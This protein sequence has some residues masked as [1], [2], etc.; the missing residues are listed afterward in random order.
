[1][2][3]FHLKLFGQSPMT[4]ACIF[5]ALFA[6]ITNRVFSQTVTTTTTTEFSSKGRCPK[7]AQHN[8]TDCDSVRDECTTSDDCNVVRICC[9]NG[10]QHVCSQPAYTACEHQRLSSEKRSRALALASDDNSTVRIPSCRSNGHFEPV[11]CDRDTGQCWCVD[12]AGFELSGTRVHSNGS[13]NCTAP[14]PCAGHL[15]RMLCPYEFELDDEGCPLCQCRDPCAGVRCPGDTQCQLEEVHCDQEPCPPVPTCKQ[16]RSLDDICPFGKALAVSERNKF[17]LCGLDQGKPQCPSFFDCIVQP[18]MEYG[19]CCPAADKLVKPGT[20]PNLTRSYNDC[21]KKCQHDMECEG[22][23]KCCLS[24]HCG[25]TCAPMAENTVCLQ[26]RILSE[27]LSVREKSGQGYIPQ[28]TEKGLFES[29]QCSRNGL[30]CWCVDVNGFKTPRSMGPAKTVECKS[31][32]EDTAVADPRSC[33]NI[34]C[35]RSCPYGFKV[36]A[37]GC[38]T[39]NCADLCESIRCPTG[40]ECVVIEN[41]FCTE[42]PCESYPACKPSPILYSK[43]GAC[44]LADLVKCTNVTCVN[45]HDCEGSQKCCSTPKCGTTCL[46]NPRPLQRLPTMC[47]YLRDFGTNAIDRVRARSLALPDLVCQP[48]G[49]YDSVQCYGGHC[50]CVNEFGTE[51]LGSRVDD[52]LKD[53]L[54][55]NATMRSKGCDG[56]LCRLGCDYGFEYGDDGCP[57]CSCRNPCGSITCPEGHQCQVVEVDCFGGF[58][59]AVPQCISAEHVPATC[60]VGQALRDPM[61]NVTR[62]CGPSSLCPSSYFCHMQEGSDSSEGLCCKKPVKPGQCPYLF[63]PK[64]GHCANASQCESDHQCQGT[65]KCCSDGCKSACLEPEMKTAC[66]HNAAAAH[67]MTQQQSVLLGDI[68]SPNCE[69]ADGSFSP[70]QCHSLGHICWCVDDAGREI[71]S[72]RT[73][74]GQQPNCTALAKP[75]SAIAL[76]NLTCSHGY[77]LNDKGCG[78]CACRDPCEDILCSRKNEECRMVKV[79]CITEPCPPIAMC[80]PRIDSPCPHGEPLPETRCSSLPGGPSCPS[81]HVCLYSPLESFLPSCCPKSRDVCFEDPKYNECPASN[82]TSWSFN[83][84]KNGC[85]SAPSG[86]CPSTTNGFSNRFDCEA[87]CPN[88]SECER[89][90]EKALHITKKT[91]GFGFIPKCKKDGNWEAMQCLPE[92]GLCWCVSTSGDYIR[93]SAVRGIPRCASSRMGRK[94]DFDE[95]KEE[96]VAVTKFFSQDSGLV[97]PAGESVHLCNASLCEG[98]VCLNQP[99]AVCRVDPCGGCQYRFFTDDHQVDCNEGLTA[100]QLDVQKIL[101]SDPWPPQAM[102]F[103]GVLLGPEI[104]LIGDMMMEALDNSAGDSLP[105]AVARR[106]ADDGFLLPLGVKMDKRT[107]LE[108][109]VVKQSLGDN[110]TEPSLTAL[111]MVVMPPRCTVTGEYASVQRQGELSWCVDQRGQ[112]IHSTLTRGFVRCSLNGVILE[113]QARG[114]V[115]TDSA[116]AHR[117]C[118]NECLNAE[119]PSRPDAICLADPCDNCRVTFVDRSSEKVQCEEKCR[120]P[121]AVGMCRAAFPRWHFSETSGECESFIFGGCLGND[122]N[123]ETE[124]ECKD[125]C[126]KPVDLCDLPKRIGMCRASMK[127]FWY[128][129]QTHQCERFIFG[130]CDGNSNNFETKEQC[131]STCPDVVLCP[132]L[133][134]VHSMQPCK[135]SALCANQTCP[136]D[137]DAV[138]S[139]DPC[140][141]SIYFI[142]FDGEKVE[143]CQ[144]TTS[145]NILRNEFYD[146]T[147]IP[148]DVNLTT[149]ASHSTSMQAN[150]ATS[151]ATTFASTESTPISVA[152]TTADILPLTKCQ[153]RRQRALQK[154][155]TH[156]PKCD[157]LGHFLPLQC[158][159][160]HLQSSEPEMTGLQP[161][162]WCVDEAGNRLPDLSKFLRGSQICQET[163]VDSVAVNLVFAHNNA[164]E[165]KGKQAQI[166]REMVAMLK[167]VQCLLMENDVNVHVL[168]RT[169]Q[170]QFTLTDNRKIDVAD[171]IQEKMD[172]GK[173]LLPLEGLNLRLDSQSSLVVKHNTAGTSI[174]DENTTEQNAVL[175]RTAVILVGLFGSIA[176]LLAVALLAFIVIRRRRSQGYYPRS[177]MESLSPINSNAIYGSE[178]DA[179]KS[180]S[181]VPW[182]PD[183]TISYS[184][185]NEKPSSSLEHDYETLRY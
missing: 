158:E 73:Q 183:L 15:C 55:C 143:S 64:F 184:N 62:A 135:R 82:Q 153:K 75:C 79:N 80:V 141:C 174:Q 12:E 134:L 71:P 114:P 108:E 89:S 81:T 116:V 27:L 164:E 2:A 13:V 6:T 165:V 185:R 4:T 44:P 103:I 17:F 96:E 61:T 7:V 83:L 109:T 146:N 25:S 31:H 43:P 3:D 110:A 42:E 181:A 126:M 77:K 84:N 23:E 144:V 1:M 95:E 88:L 57:V 101:N 87:T 106:Q 132:R 149:L 167:E 136:A 76:C 19:V 107:D 56:L 98:K 93:G 177:S 51:V 157:S 39:C 11:Q 131:D 50:W 72:T 148:D 154:G 16:P 65:K 118:T 151:E 120:Q 145:V 115:C 97:C 142:N 5:L 9:F 161:K 173:M 66:E 28:C 111:S 91:S 52:S 124:Q 104:G 133:D 119:C 117:V 10:C 29:K 113:R 86:M 22:L 36:D 175:S 170:V 172:S 92:I 78:T 8:Q 127:R 67:Y 58:C 169:L 159:N 74:S 99:N 176:V 85:E 102:D 30:I 129:K 70:I 166:K 150:E 45:D 180:F 156:V 182:S 59:P 47:E 160:E 26:Q 121:L 40:T 68:H 35:A 38:Q 139:V 105:L 130:G 41:D 147:E 152:A 112:P 125:E 179:T 20:C 48:D 168:P 123:F 94:L 122:N 140:D 90:R 34:L 24:D 60:P 137:P 37:N 21:G 100:C 54:D 18:G 138:C 162:C 14:R 178:K 171:L 69:D 128:N 63:E 32:T 49:R 33:D 46:G 53:K 155:S 163:K